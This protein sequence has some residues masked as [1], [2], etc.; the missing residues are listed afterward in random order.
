M[1][2]DRVLPMS[3]AECRAARAF[4]DWSQSALAEN[5]GIGVSTLRKFELGITVMT[6]NNMRAVT[7]AFDRGGVWILDRNDCGPGI[8]AAPFRFRG[9]SSDVGLNVEVRLDE[10]QMA[11]DRTFDLWFRFDPGALSILSGRPIADE[12]HAKATVRANLSRAMRS[13]RNWIATKGMGSKG[14]GP[15]ILTAQDMAPV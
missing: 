3:P 13:V 12:E 9:Y 15:R 4:L 14:G 6:R 7:E 11:V 8:V 1:V 2:H 5:A 10:P